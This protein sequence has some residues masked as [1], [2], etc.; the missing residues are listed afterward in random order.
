MYEIS[1]APKRLNICMLAC[2]LLQSSAAAAVSAAE[3][4]DS[5]VNSWSL[6]CSDSQSIKAFWKPSI[7]K[8]NPNAPQEDLRINCG[9][10]NFKSESET[11]KQF[12]IAVKQGRRAVLQDGPRTTF[13]S[14]VW[15]P[16]CS[17]AVASQWEE[18]LDYLE[19]FRPNKVVQSFVGMF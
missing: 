14:P 11:H 19:N 7:Q 2:C 18:G 3:G 8:L 15:T 1:H 9:A 10:P 5:T 13:P 17:A 6:A 16:T 4:L 12:G